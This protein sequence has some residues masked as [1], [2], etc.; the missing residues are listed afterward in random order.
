MPIFSRNLIVCCTKFSSEFMVE[1]REMNK[2]QPDFREIQKESTT[3]FQF[4]DHWID[5]TAERNNNFVCSPQNEMAS[6]GRSGTTES[7]A[8]LENADSHAGNV[9]SLFFCPYCPST[10]SRVYFSDLND[11][12]GHLTSVHED[13]HM[14]FLSQKLPRLHRCAFCTYEYE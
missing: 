11:L 7:T 4:T 13:V 2:N 14:K 1:R 9:N 12:Q 6:A 10:E 8:R 3:S 5:V